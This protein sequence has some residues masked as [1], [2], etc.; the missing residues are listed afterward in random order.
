MNIK[1]NPADL[2]WW[3]WTVTLLF[4]VAAVA[5]WTPGY[6]IVIAISAAQ[7]VYFL[8]QE[9]S[10]SAFPTQIRIVLIGTIMVTFFG[11]CAIALVLKRVPWNRGREVRL[12]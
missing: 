2:R 4:I 1:T 8:A 12:N 5:G 11:R 6:G 10:V 3:F 9:R 7:V